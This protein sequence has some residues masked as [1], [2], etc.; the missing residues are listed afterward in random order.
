MSANVTCSNAAF[1][2]TP[3]SIITGRSQQLTLTGPRTS[4]A[5]QGLHGNGATGPSTAR[6]MSPNVCRFRAHIRPPFPCS[7]NPALFNASNT[8]SRIFVFLLVVQ[9]PG[10]TTSLRFRSAKHTNAGWHIRFFEASF[11]FT[12]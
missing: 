5:T 12:H 8:C 7:A 9:F 10:W 4:P 1:T 6:T 2:A 3:T 11:L